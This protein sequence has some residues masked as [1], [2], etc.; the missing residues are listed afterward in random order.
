M[1][2]KTHFEQPTHSFSSFFQTIFENH[3]AVWRGRV[4]SQEFQRRE[5]EKNEVGWMSWLMQN[6][7]RYTWIGAILPIVRGRPNSYLIRRRTYQPYC[8]N[9]LKITFNA[10]FAMNVT[11]DVTDPFNNIIYNNSA[12]STRYIE[13]PLSRFQ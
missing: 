5:K 3:V 9:T 10:T 8:V 11:T 2:V 13:L 12:N 1:A 4:R 6:T 7:D